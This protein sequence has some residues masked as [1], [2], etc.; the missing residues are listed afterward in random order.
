MCWWI[1]DSNCPLEI[2][3]VLKIFEIWCKAGDI[4]NEFRPERVDGICAFIDA[5]KELGGRAWGIIMEFKSEKSVCTLSVWIAGILLELL[6]HV[7]LDCELELEIVVFGLDI[8]LNPFGEEEKRFS[9]IALKFSV[10]NGYG[11]GACNPDFIPDADGVAFDFGCGSPIEKKAD[12]D[13][14]RAWSVGEKWDGGGEVDFC[15]SW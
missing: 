6:L 2:N 9:P 15:W 4:I 14:R 1:I 12:A 11:K 3:G 7:S 8:K 5:T 10:E 13:A